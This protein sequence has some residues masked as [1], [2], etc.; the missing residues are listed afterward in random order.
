MYEV[1]WDKI[2]YQVAGEQWYEHVVFEGRFL[3][4]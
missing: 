2:V 4:Q 3:N 1:Y